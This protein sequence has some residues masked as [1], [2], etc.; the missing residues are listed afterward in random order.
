VPRD[1]SVLTDELVCCEF[2]CQTWPEC[3]QTKK[4]T[5]KESV[6]L[7]LPIYSA[8]PLPTSF[9]NARNSAVSSALSFI[10]RDRVVTRA[11]PWRLVSRT[12]RRSGVS[13][14]TG[15]LTGF[16]ITAR[17]AD[18][19]AVMAPRRM[20]ALLSNHLDGVAPLEW[21]STVLAWLVLC[22]SDPDASEEAAYLQFQHKWNT[23]TA[24][25]DHKCTEC[26]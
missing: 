6:V 3:A 21:R 10:M 25:A 8:I 16:L 1:Y 12:C 14:A 23:D 4:K 15:V 9:S 26:V 2:V 11:T 24:A 5:N 19:E 18:V 7:H 22:T 13:H 17:A 20:L